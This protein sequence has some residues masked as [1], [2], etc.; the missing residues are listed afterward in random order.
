MNNFVSK[1][2]SVLAVFLLLVYAGYQVYRYVYTPYRTE[3]AYEYTV[4]D[5]L[6]CEGLVVRDEV[7]L[8]QQGSGSVSYYVSDDPTMF[9]TS[10]SLFLGGEINGTVEKININEY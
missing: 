2:V 9:V 4:Y 1:L 5:S 3:T 6:Y 7:A 8:Q 10:A